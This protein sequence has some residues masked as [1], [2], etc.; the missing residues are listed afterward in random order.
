MIS[1]YYGYSDEYICEKDSDWRGLKIKEIL[2]NETSGRLYNLKLTSMSHQP[3][4]ENAATSLQNA[5]SEEFRRQT[6][7]LKFAT[8]AYAYEMNESEEEEDL[9][10]G[11]MRYVE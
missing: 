8:D 2:K 1:Y 11:T 6:N 4:S 5:F 9:G 3:G 10:D 7:L